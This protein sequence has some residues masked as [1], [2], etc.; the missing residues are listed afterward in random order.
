MNLKPDKMK[1]DTHVE[2]KGWIDAVDSKG[3]LVPLEHADAKK[4]YCKIAVGNWFVS[5]R[6]PR[7]VL[8]LRPEQQS[9]YLDKVNERLIAKMVKALAARGVDIVATHSDKTTAGQIESLAQKDKPSPA[10]KFEEAG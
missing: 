7:H 10:F 1:A 3:H 6:L 5:E 8:K 4:L 9:A 2:F